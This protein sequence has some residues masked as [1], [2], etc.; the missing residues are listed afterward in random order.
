VISLYG[1]AAEA[2]EMDFS[3]DVNSLISQIEIYDQVWFVRHCP[4]H[5]R[6]STEAIDLVKEF[7][8]RLEDIPIDDAVLFPYDTI[9]ELK[10]EYL[11]I[12]CD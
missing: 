3:Y 6:H 4:K 1:H 2:N 8:R 9:D 10:K 11:R 12:D 7:V 5:G